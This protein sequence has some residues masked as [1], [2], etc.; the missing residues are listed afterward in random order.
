MFLSLWSFTELMA[1]G[2]ES[3]LW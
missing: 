2:K 3:L 1:I